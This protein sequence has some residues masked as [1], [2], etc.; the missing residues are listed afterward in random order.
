MP[1]DLRLPERLEHSLTEE[2]PAVIT[3]EGCK[4]DLLPLQQ[5]ELHPESTALYLRLIRELRG[6][7]REALQRLYAIRGQEILTPLKY[8]QAHELPMHFIDAHW[9]TWFRM[10]P[11]AFFSTLR[12]EKTLQN[13]IQGMNVSPQ[14]CVQFDAD[15][16]YTCIRKFHD[17]RSV[18]DETDFLNRTHWR[19]LLLSPQ[20]GSDR[21]N[22]PAAYLREIASKTMGKIVHVCHAVHTLDDV[23]GQTIF[24]KLRQS[25]LPVQ[26]TTILPAA[27]RATRSTLH[28]SQR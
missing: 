9:T 7:V 19:K 28:L 22:V 21:D 15:G 4:S 10:N 20:D 1:F 3:V 6:H 23:N 11:A 26:R 14:G 2:E 24:A 25:R 13:F 16:W 18:A 17:H 8:A 5:R 27:R 12:D